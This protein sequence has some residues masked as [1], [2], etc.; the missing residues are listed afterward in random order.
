MVLTAGS[1][2]LIWLT[3]DV[4]KANYEILDLNPCKDNFL[5]YAS[6]SS[7]ARQNWNWCKYVTLHHE[8][9]LV[10]PNI[11]FEILQYSKSVFSPLLNG[12]NGLK[13]A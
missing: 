11:N 2:S 5:C 13:I 7:D 1:Q 6:F 12:E 8:I 10:P 9:G 4:I 3:F